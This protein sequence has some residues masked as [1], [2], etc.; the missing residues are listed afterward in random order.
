MQ[1]AVFKQTTVRLCNDLFDGLGFAKRPDASAWADVYVMVG[2]FAHE[3]MGFQALQE[4][5]PLVAGS[6]GGR[7]FPQWTGYGRAAGAA[8]SRRGAFRS[9]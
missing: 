6:K 4:K 8:S 3:C 1:S 5:K 2:N 7:G 9:A